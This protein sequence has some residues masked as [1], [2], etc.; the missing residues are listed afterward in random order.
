K[1]EGIEEHYIRAKE[2]KKKYDELPKIDLEMQRIE[3]EMEKLEEHLRYLQSQKEELESKL[4]E[5]SIHQI[6]QR[7]SPGELCPVCGNKVHTVPKLSD[8]ETWDFTQIRQELD[9]IRK[10]EE[11]AFNKR[12]DLKFQKSQFEQ[13]RSEL[14]NYEE[15]YKSYT[16]LEED[17]KTFRRLRDREKELREER[18]KIMSDLLKKSQE[19]SGAI[20]SLEH[21]I[22]NLEEQKEEKRRILEKLGRQIENPQRELLLIEQEL[23]EK[24]KKIKEVQERYENTRNYIEKLNNMLLVIDEKIKQNEKRREEIREELGKV[25]TAL[26]PAIKKFGDI[27]KLRS[28]RLP[29][30]ELQRLEEEISHYKMSVERLQED[31]R[32][33]ENALAVYP[34]DMDR[35]SIEEQLESLE[36]TLRQMYQDKGS[37]SKELEQSKEKMRRKKDIEQELIG[38]MREIQKYEI[39]ERDLRS[40]RF[41]EFISRYMLQSILERASYYLFKFS[42]GLYEFK[43]VDSDKDNL[44]VIDRSSGHERSVLTLSGGE[45]FLASLSLAFAVSDIV[46]HNAPLESMFI[47]EGFGSLD[48]E[49]RESLGEFFELIKSNAGRMVGIISHLE[50]LAE[51]FDQR[52]LI[53]K[54][55]DQ[56][57]IKILS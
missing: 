32:K 5:A 1:L 52:I 2:L 4:F 33:L 30:E 27:D 7:L 40:D 43:L 29:K 31:V 45:T 21:L 54:R 25:G 37:L 36:S 57:V 50:D 38:L 14:A 46:S 26:M 35:K 18:E 24:E 47:D 23:V 8:K 55:G 44:Y 48:R 51:K 13:K 19:L 6:A 39:L 10:Q 34:K 20:T 28:L 12:A 17:Y 49:T 3:K 42:S 11:E 9:R 41:P 16:K 53:E 56:S 15:F 22:K